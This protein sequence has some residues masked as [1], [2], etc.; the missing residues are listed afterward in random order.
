MLLCQQSRRKF[1]FFFFFFL[2]IKNWFCA[3]YCCLA[4]VQNKHI[5][6]SEAFLIEIISVWS[7]LLKSE[8]A[9]VAPESVLNS[10]EACGAR[11]DLRPMRGWGWA[12]SHWNR[13]WCMT[14][15]NSIII[16]ADHEGTFR[17][18]GQSGK[19]SSPL[20]VCQCTCTLSIDSFQLSF[21]KLNWNL[22]I[23]RFSYISKPTFISGELWRWQARRTPGV[24]W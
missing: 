4:A 24:S 23:N 10:P 6:Q 20:W 19:G 5:M 13:S 18:W 2:I 3:L 21:S 22:S 7:E 17:L 1:L 16:H 15:L 12:E 14:I 9:D 8:G 11:A